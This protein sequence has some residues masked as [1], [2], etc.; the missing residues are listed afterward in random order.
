MVEAALTEWQPMAT[1]PRN[2]SRLIIAIRAGEQGAAEVDVVRWGTAKRG[3]IVCWIS[4]DSSHDCTIL[5]HEAEVAFWMALPSSMP[6][7][8][9][10]GMAALL[11]AVPPT[12]ADGSG[13]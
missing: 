6:F 2:G 12:E 3:D 5:Y 9:T 10:P 11:P 8:R 13:I 4:T 1:A 7:S